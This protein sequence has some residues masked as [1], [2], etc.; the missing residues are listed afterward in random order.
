MRE[1][2]SDQSK[3]RRRGFLATTGAAI[4]G[5]SVVPA[6]VSA[7]KD[8]VAIYE[9]ARRKRQKNSWSVGKWADYLR[10]KSRGHDIDFDRRRDV[11]SRPANPSSGSS[12]DGPSTQK[13]EQDKL[14]FDCT[15]TKCGTGYDANIYANAYFEVDEGW[16]RDGE[17]PMDGVGFGWDVDE[18]DFNGDETSGWWVSEEKDGFGN[19]LVGLREFSGRGIAFEFRD[20]GHAKEGH[21]AEALLK[22]EGGTPD[23]RNVIYEYVHSYNDSKLKELG[24]ATDGTITMTVEPYT[25][26]WDDPVQDQIFESNAQ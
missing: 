2:D 25:A 3:Q 24:V 6:A 26:K 16:L 9:K 22:I 11:Y 8:P 4:T 20:N 14:T 5:L 13:F 23:T 19:T 7:K 1:A 12:S 10:K 21:W 15:L 17:A 18:Y